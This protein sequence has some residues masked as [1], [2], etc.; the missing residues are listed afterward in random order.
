MWVQ[1][2]DGKNYQAPGAPSIERCSNRSMQR[3]MGAF[4]IGS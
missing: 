4:G 3:R 2:T 1:G